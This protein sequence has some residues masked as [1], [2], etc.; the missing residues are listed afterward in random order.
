[1][2]MGALPTC[3]GTVTQV[4]RPHR[5]K[6]EGK[7]PVSPR[8]PVALGTVIDVAIPALSVFTVAMMHPPSPQTAIVGGKGKS[9]A[10]ACTVT[11]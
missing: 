5:E 7:L 8:S 9:S 2:G 3:T 1:M 6:I 11:T 10:C 4:R